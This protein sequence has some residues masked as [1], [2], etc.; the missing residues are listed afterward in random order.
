[1]AKLRNV[2]D[3]P[4]EVRALGRTVDVDEV[5]E[6]PDDFYDQHAWPETLWAVVTG[7]KPA[8]KTTAKDEE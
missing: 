5:L 4:L 7:S 6:V 8:R 2:S 1:M 3:A